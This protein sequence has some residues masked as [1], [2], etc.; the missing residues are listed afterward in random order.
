[1]KKEIVKKCKQKAA[2]LSTVLLLTSC[3]STTFAAPPTELETGGFAVGAGTGDHTNDYFIETKLGDTFTLGGERVQ[4]RSGSGDTT[5]DIYGK[6]DMMSENADEDAIKWQLI[7]GRRDFSDSGRKYIGAGA[8]KNIGEGWSV[9]SSIIAGQSFEEVQA[10]L[11][12]PIN[13]QSNLNLSYRNCRHNGDHDD[14]YIGI[15]VKI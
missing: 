8:S 15:A 7:L 4:W 13:E 10:G 6:I 1:M 9:Y 11:L 12:Y 5:T 14:I 2:L 3:T